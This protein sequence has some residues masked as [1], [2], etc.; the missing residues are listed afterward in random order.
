VTRGLFISFEGG[1]ASGKS[2]QAKRLAE[3]LE[4]DG[5]DVVLT[6]EPGG[7]PLGERIRDIVLHTEDVP[8]A[9][10]ADVL[11][12]SAARAQHVRDVIRPALA[13]G[14]VVIT[15]RFLDSTA[16]YQGAGHGAD[17]AGVSAVTAFAVGGTRPDRTYV[18]DLPLEAALQRRAGHDRRWDRFEVSE[19]EFHQRLREG[20][21]RLAAAEPD[22]VVV[23]DGNRELDAIARDIRRDVDIV[24]RAVPR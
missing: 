18:L 4:R 6:R 24:L 22:R 10:E 21:L 13:A 2:V 1:E 20:Y 5:H 15:D 12:F 9:P 23:I 14:K 3:S 19:R 16:A 8:L 17:A 7:T 11:L